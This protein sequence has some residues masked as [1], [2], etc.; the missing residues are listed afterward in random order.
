MKTH[1]F[2]STL[3][4]KSQQ[5]IIEL[6][7][8]PATFKAS[9]FTSKVKDYPGANMVVLH[10]PVSWDPTDVFSLVMAVRAMNRSCQMSNYTVLVGCGL[11]NVHLLREAL[12]RCGHTLKF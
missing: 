9:T 5:N 7:T 12:Y 8:R 2:T 3:I 6:V 1:F 11:S 10:T 4:V